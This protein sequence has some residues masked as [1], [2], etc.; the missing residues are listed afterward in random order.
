MAGQQIFNVK[1]LFSLLY[2]SK[3]LSV[4]QFHYRK[5]EMAGG[6]YL[7]KQVAN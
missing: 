2:R 7:M 1:N 3:K 5:Y 4:K 6:A